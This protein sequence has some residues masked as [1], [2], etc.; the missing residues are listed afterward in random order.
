M[1]TSFLK[2]VNFIWELPSPKNISYLWGFGSMLGLIMVMQVASGFMLTFYY[3][4]GTL[5]WDS[6]IELTREVSSG[7]LLRLMH[8]SN[9]SFV[10]FFLFIHMSRGLV[11]SSFL[12]QGPWVTGWT[13]MVL[14]MGAAFLGY[15]LPWG[16]MSFWGATVII[17]LLSVLPYGKT[18]VI[19]LWGGFY[20]S[21]FTCSFFYALHYILPFVVLVMSMVHLFFLHNAGSSV[22]GGLSSFEGL[23][24]KFGHFFLYK[25]FV[26]LVLL[27][28]S[29]IFILYR[30]DFFSDPV[31]FMIS[32]LSNSPI[33]IQPE[34]YFL[35]FY[36]VLRAIPN[37]LGGLIGF[38][39]AIVVLP[40]LSVMNFK[41]NLSHFCLYDLFIW[42]FM[43]SNMLLMWLGSQP[44]EEPFILMSQFCTFLYF[45]TLILFMLEKSFSYILEE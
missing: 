34:W 27:W 41:H 26:N 10:F 17:N 24:V 25:D 3:V 4:S 30:P 9:A 42:A 21:F 32:D 20:V 6:V 29:W 37:K 16:Q 31:N 33:H 8:A 44:V 2:K 40:L 14:T 11:Q 38:V 1:S 36:A 39:L 22:S 19:W 28:F 35:H 43:S 5:A 12:M 13:I 15:V 7:W 23:K 45:L 18:L